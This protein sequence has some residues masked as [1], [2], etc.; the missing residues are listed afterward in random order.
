MKLLL[1]LLYIIYWGTT[2]AKPCRQQLLL[3]TVNVQP[4][5]PKPDN[6]RPAAS[7]T[8]MPSAHRSA[9]SPANSTSKVAVELPLLEELSTVKFS[10]LIVFLNPD[11]SHPL[12]TI[13]LLTAAG[14]TAT[15]GAPSLTLKESESGV[16]QELL[17]LEVSKTNVYLVTALLES[18]LLSTLIDQS[19]SS[20]VWP[21]HLLPP[22][23]FMHSGSPAKTWAL[24]GRGTELLNKRGNHLDPP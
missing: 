18:N 11:L 1:V 19:A 21:K 16:P 7:T 15:T 10:H 2:S 8:L 6:T 23:C 9:T 14:A 12:S 17:L 24:S 4:A 3:L 22:A 20:A 13:L 5:S